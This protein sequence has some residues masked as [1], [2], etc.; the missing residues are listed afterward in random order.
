MASLKLFILA[1]LLC[2]HVLSLPV[3]HRR[4]GDRH[5]GKRRGNRR[6][7]RNK[8]VH[9]NVHHHYYGNGDGYGT[10]VATNGNPPAVTTAYYDEASPNMEVNDG[11]VPMMDQVKEDVRKN[12]GEKFLDDILLPIKQVEADDKNEAAPKGEVNDGKMS[13]EQV[14]DQN[15]P[16]VGEKYG[17]NKLQMKQFD[18]DGRSM[19]HHSERR[20]YL[21]AEK[22][23]RR[24]SRGKSNQ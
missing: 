17:Y 12:V 24:N 20:A 6:R 7:N 19:P 15:E 2:G 16:D 14:D 3:P 13:M 9:I 18:A 22:E 8:I 21:R 4:H 10:G 11:K 1:A 5:G 23:R